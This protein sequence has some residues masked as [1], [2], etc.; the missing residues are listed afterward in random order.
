[1]KIS[2]IALGAAMFA[3]MLA[4]LATPV[5]RAA[6]APTFTSK[7]EKYSIY[8]PAKPRMSSR[9]MALPGMG[10]IQV[11]FIS[12]AK[13]P[14]T[15]VVVP[16]RLPGT[17]GNANIIHFLDGVERGFTKSASAKLISRKK[18]SLNGATGREILVQV[19]SNL[20]RGRFFVKGNRSYQVVAISPRSGSARY[21]AQILQ[22]LDSFRILK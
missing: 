19:G 6:P 22:V 3:S 21:N 8:L 20:M 1:M 15:F 13:P 11:N 18:I 9:I 4:P 17:P 10:R 7:T 16:M 12:V 2:Q 14:T 5:V